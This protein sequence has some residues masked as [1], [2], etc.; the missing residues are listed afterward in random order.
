MWLGGAAPTLR[1]MPH[2]SPLTEAE[3]KLLREAL[4]NARRVLGAVTGAT[5]Q[6]RLGQGRMEL[7]FTVE[8]NQLDA[9]LL[10]VTS[11]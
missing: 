4:L 9:A 3:L 6:H 1:T 5:V 2:V 10:L 8:I 7:D 11:L